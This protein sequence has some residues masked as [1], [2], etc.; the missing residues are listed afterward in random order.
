MKTR[1][2]T[3]HTDLE[4]IE[5]VR[6][7]LGPDAI[8]LNIK[9]IRPRGIFAVFRKQSVEI[10]AAYEEKNAAKQNTGAASQNQ[11]QT[12]AQGLDKILLEEQT[13]VRDLEC[14]L[15]ETELTLGRLMG[16]LDIAERT[17]RDGGN[18]K[19]DDSMIQLFYDT[20]LKNGVLPEV[21][22]SLLND[23]E[24]VEKNNKMG[25]PFITKIVYNNI[26]N[27]LKAREIPETWDCSKGHAEYVFFMGPTG[28]GKTTTIAKISA[29]LVLGEKKKVRLVTADTYRIAAV[30]QLKTYAEILGIGVDVAYGAEDL[31]KNIGGAKETAETVL[32]DT[33]GR[34]HKNAE[35]MNELREMLAAVPES[36]KFLVLGLNMKREDML[37]VVNAYAGVG[38]FRLIFTKADETDNLG[39]ILN[40]CWLTGKKPAYV[41]N[42]QS[43]P[44]DIE[45]AK[46]EKIAKA[47]LGMGGGSDD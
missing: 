6:N 34:S 45:A 47:L 10:T 24:K 13:K 8:V 44:D 23:V 43:V 12:N 26:I 18:R 42:G 2:F 29:K 28:V 7:E 15:S 39:E 33:A 16:Q 35:N 27:I 40:I 3:A 37:A 22:E 36:E 46:P 4:A 32:I 38:D 5:A 41:T 20:L 21:A 17:L 31:R 30:E 19:Y 11:A 14:K 9:K 25:I 1:K